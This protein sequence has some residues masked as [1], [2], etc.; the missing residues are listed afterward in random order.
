[1]GAGAVPSSWEACCLQTM[2]PCLEHRERWGQQAIAIVG[3][4][5]AVGDSHLQKCPVAS[6]SLP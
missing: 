4:S 5:Q 1:M 3:L 2:H 6:E